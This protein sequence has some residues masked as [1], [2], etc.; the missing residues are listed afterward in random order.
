MLSCRPHVG[1]WGLQWLHGCEMVPTVHA[2][3]EHGLQSWTVPHGFPIDCG[4]RLQLA[5]SWSHGQNV[6]SP[7][8]QGNQ[9]SRVHSERLASMLLRCIFVT[10]WCVGSS[11]NFLFRSCCCLL[12]RIRNHS[13]NNESL[14]STYFALSMVLSDY[15]HMNSP[16]SHNNL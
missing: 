5:G 16:N 1:N 2:V 9:L 12:S 8:T 14:L 13:N 10:K 7:K 4:A 11:G 6:P 15:T 3:I